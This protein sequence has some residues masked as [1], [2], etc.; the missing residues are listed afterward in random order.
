MSIVLFTGCTS[1]NAK[2]ESKEYTEVEI[3]V[4]DATSLDMAETDKNIVIYETEKINEEQ[5]LVNTKGASLSESEVSKVNTKE[6][7]P[8]TTTKQANTIQ[9][10]SS[11]E[12]NNNTILGSQQTTT[13]QIPIR[14]TTANSTVT[15]NEV[16]GTNATNASND[17]KYKDGSHTGSGEGYDGIIKVRVN[18]KEGKINGIEVISH[19]DTPGLAVNAFAKITENII[20]SQSLSVDT[21]S[22]ATGSSRGFIEAVKKALNK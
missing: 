1:K 12:A 21:V 7:K 18:V 14:T 22:G 5:Q 16:E 4:A 2:I 15:N 17:A 3:E 11:E 13:S 6:G 9:K 10:E 8:K 20:S 19:E